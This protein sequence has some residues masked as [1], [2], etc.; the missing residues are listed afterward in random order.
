MNFAVNN[1]LSN[2]G[3]EEVAPYRK[4]E[5]SEVLS[6]KSGYNVKESIRRGT[7]GPKRAL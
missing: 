3:C 5:R 7:E 2:K 6:K 1:C 4:S